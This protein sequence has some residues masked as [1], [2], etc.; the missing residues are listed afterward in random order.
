MTIRPTRASAACNT[1]LACTIGAFAILAA[2]CTAEAESASTTTSAN[3]AVSTSP[4]ASSSAAEPG[5]S[6]ASS[7]GSPSPEESAPAPADG[8]SAT[9]EA[10]ASSDADA[11]YQG[12]TPDSTMAL[13]SP[14]ALP[15]PA[16]TAGPVPT[17]GRIDQEVANVEVVTNA[18]VPFD[19]AGDFG[20]NVVSRLVEVKAID[21]TAQLPGEI[22]G[23]AVAVVVEIENQSAETIGLDGVTVTLAD[24][25][26]A[27]ASSVSSVPAQPVSGALAPGEKRSGVYVFTTAL[28]ARTA[29]TISVSYSTGAP[30]VLFTGSA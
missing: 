10:T 26:G 8:A 27:P 22:A 9:P 21:A 30:T 20:G 3:S 6:T 1:L 5:T 18:P 24:A 23:P 12:A 16:A 11:T 2:A 17:P 4:S 28:D 25:N 19:A 7:D 13:P 14:S 29:M 15:A